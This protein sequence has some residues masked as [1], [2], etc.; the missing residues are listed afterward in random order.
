MRSASETRSRGPVLS[1]Y[2]HYGRGFALFLCLLIGQCSLHLESPEQDAK[3][4]LAKVI[5]TRMELLLGRWVADSTYNVDDTRATSLGGTGVL[6]EILADTTYTQIDTNIQA[7]PKR[8]AEGV[9]YLHGDTLIVFPLTAAPD[10]FI[11]HLRFM[12]NYLELFRS[13]DQRFTF[14]HKLKPNDSLSTDSLLRDSLWRMDGHRVDP[15]IYMAETHAVDFSYLRFSGD[16][17]FADVRRDGVIRADSGVVDKADSLWTWRAAGGTKVFIADLVKPDSLRLWPLS[18]GRPDSGFYLYQRVSR[19]HPNDL[20]MRR[21]MGHMRGDSTLYPDRLVVNHYGQY[22]DWILGEDHK[23]TVETNIGNVP[24]WTAWNLDSGFL[25]LRAPG[26]G[27]QRVRMDTLAGGVRLLAD[28]SVVYAKGTF[29]WQTRVDPA[30]F[31][32]RPLERFQQASYLILVI[33]GDTT[34]YFFNAN[35]I[36]ERFEI[37]AAIGGAVYWSAFVLNLSLETFQSGQPDFFFAFEGRTPALGK[38]TCR[39]RPDRDMV[40][41]QTVSAD[42][43]LAEGLLQGSCVILKADSV[44]TDSILALDG[45]FRMLKRNRNNL[46]ANVWSLQ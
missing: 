22:C 1:R 25:S 2:R 38:F 12:G 6:L 3:N 30:R 11:A 9:F 7:F 32:E 31:K 21:M 42:P 33:G 14:F 20:D 44:F 4:K 26:L 28:T 19:H 10:T 35:N 43:A 34:F 8:T 45:A 39:S 29:I 46:T 17:M 16:S 18:Q 5:P 23:V 13:A 24:L 37:S 41:R 36:K 40:I 15:G 27:P